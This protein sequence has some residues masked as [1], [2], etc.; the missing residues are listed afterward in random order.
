MNL[1]QVLPA[2][3]AAGSP[4]RACRVERWDWQPGA[5]EFACVAARQ[6]RCGGSATV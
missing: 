4:E 5:G 1:V 2:G 6:L 3:S